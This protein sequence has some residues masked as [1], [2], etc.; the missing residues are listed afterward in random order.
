MLATKPPWITIRYQDN[1]TLRSIKEEVKSKGLATVCQESLCPNLSECWGSGTATFMLM[2]DTCTRGC[3]FCFVKTAAIPSPL[4]PDEPKLLLAAIQ[5][6]KLS[7]VVL[8]TVDRDDLPDQGAYHLAQCVKFLKKNLPH[9]KVEILIPDFRGDTELVK[10]ILDAK[11]DVIAHNLE[12]VRRLTPKV[13]DRRASY[14]QS[15]TV[16]KFC[17]K[18]C[19]YT[20]SSLMVGH[21]ETK[22]EISQAMDDLRSV[23]VTFLTIGQ[24]LRPSHRQLEVQDYLT[25]DTFK[26][27]ES[28]GLSKGFL[29]VAAG[30]FVRSSYKAGELFVEHLLKRGEDNAN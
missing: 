8:T 27:Y 15:L 29:Y 17:N 25:P 13:R 14:D 30:P 28:L 4:N 2:G 10:K 23:G 26:Y 11:S 1:P 18:F 6:M 22:E 20:K 16:L 21:G 9:L 5:H 7:Y 3:R 24:Y 12:T 19:P